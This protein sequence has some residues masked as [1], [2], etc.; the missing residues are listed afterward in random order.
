MQFLG[1]SSMEHVQI[2]GGTKSQSVWN[3]GGS[4][5][6][7]LSLPSLQIKGLVP[8]LGVGWIGKQ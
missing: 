7:Y 1:L 6:L 3:L 2:G 8:R 4:A 5:N